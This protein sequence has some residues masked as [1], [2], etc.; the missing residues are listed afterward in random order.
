VRVPQAERLEAFA[1][2]HYW[3]S[4][5]KLGY[6]RQWNSDEKTVWQEYF[7]ALGYHGLWREWNA[8]G[9]LFRVFPRYYVNDVQVTRRQ[10]LKA[11][12]SD[13][14]LPPYRPEEDDPQ[15]PLPAEYLAQ[16]HQGS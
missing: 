4:E 12:Q 9:R 1:E 8:R 6:K 14:T 5:G 15:R 13:P 10:Y 11:C 2:E 16:R 7:Y 3:P